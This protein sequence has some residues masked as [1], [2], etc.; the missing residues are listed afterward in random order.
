LFATIKLSA[1]KRII[2]MI[3]NI[4]SIL[5]ASLLSLSAGNAL[6]AF[7]DLRLIRVYYDRAGA[8]LSTDMGSVTTILTSA[9]PNTVKGSFSDISG[10][11][12]TL[13]AYFALDRAG[14]RFWV[15]GIDITAAAATFAPATLGSLTGINNG[16]TPMY[17]QFNT[18]G[19]TNYSGLA[20]NPSSYKNKISSVQGYFSNTVTAANN[21]RT[22]SEATIANAPV[23]QTLWY[24]SNG[25]A[26][27]A[28]GKTGVA[29]ATI[30]TNADGS[31]T[32]TP[33][34]TRNDGAC[35]AASGQTL[36]TAPTSNL[37]TTGAPSAVSTGNGPWTWGCSG[38]G[39]AAVSAN[40]ATG[41]IYTITKSVVPDPLTGE[42][43]T[44]NCVSP[45][46]PGGSSVC[47][48]TPGA[49]S[50]LASLTDDGNNVTAS[51]T[52]NSYSITNVQANHTVEAT[53]AAGVI[54]TSQA[55]GA[56]TLTPPSLTVG[57]TTVASAT[58][59][60]GYPVSFGVV[61][62]IPTIC[63]IS[64]ATVTGVAEGDCTVTA[65]QAGDATFAIAPQVTQVIKV[66]PPIIKINT[67]TVPDN[68]LNA[69]LAIPVANAD[70]YLQSDNQ[71]SLAPLFAE[72]VVMTNPVKIKLHG[73]YTDAAFTNQTTTTTI[74][75]SLT[76][77][78][79]TLIADKINIKAVF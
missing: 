42:T 77:K 75:G 66:V 14:N 58:A 40:C 55:I 39:I 59:S 49:G 57:R 65:D 8:E 20:S 62:N 45:V 47:T 41:L 13:A 68:T 3:K 72:D 52:N 33:I 23:T 74:K 38:K 25:L 56:I 69:A 46:A 21:A 32:I 30:V 76:I 4:I 71:L 37:C 54:K 2:A 27:T 28:G 78:G 31:T 18:Q 1:H 79:G 70:I 53:F 63:T 67:A 35:G 5:T 43:G 73:G 50:I 11:A 36:L 15:S 19:G 12:T 51:V 29:V 7:A 6:A 22:Y 44:L 26:T 16:T 10:T 17:A 48:I 24:W 9:T 61:S 64:G 60:S 34:T